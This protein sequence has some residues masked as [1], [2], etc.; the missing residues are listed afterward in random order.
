MHPV[1]KRNQ[2]IHLKINSNQLSFI[3]SCQL[4]NGTLIAEGSFVTLKNEAIPQAA[5][6]V[7]IVEA[8]QCN[9]ELIKRKGILTLASS[10]NAEL[11]KQNIMF[12]R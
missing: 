6:I 12:P 5:D 1:I 4:N 3:S 7:F 10:L 8:K 9:S 11:K 2:L